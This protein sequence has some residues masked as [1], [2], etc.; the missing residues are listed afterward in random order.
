MRR[1][2]VRLVLAASV[3]HALA[4]PV[5]PTQYRVGSSVNGSRRRAS[6]TPR[7]Q[8]NPASSLL[9]NF[10]AGGIAGTLASVATQPF[11]V[12]KTKMQQAAT[13]SQD[14][15]FGMHAI[16]SGGVAQTLASV[17]QR[18]GI[19]ALWTGALPVLLLAF[20]ESALQLSTHDLCL[21]HFAAPGQSEESLPLLLQVFAGCLSGVPSVLATNPMDMLA[22][23]ASDEQ[24]AA[25]V[26][27]ST[28]LLSNV[29][30]LGLEGLYDGSATTWLRDVPFLGIYFP[31]FAGL[32]ASLASAF[33]SL[34]ILPP[35]VSAVLEA[36]MAGT[37]AGMVASALT[38]PCDVVNVAVK[39]RLMREA[40]PANVFSASL[41]PASPSFP[42]KHSECLKLTTAFSK[43]GSSRAGKWTGRGS[44]PIQLKLVAEVA[45]ELHAEKGP[46]AFF[47]G[48]HA[49]VGQVMPAQSLTICIYN[50]LHWLQS[51]AA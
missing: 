16:G 48:I 31:L 30:A 18:D 25:G 4:F 9:F 5:V 7:M 1:R 10:C 13:V 19:P 43:S 24:Y 38:V 2:L 3:V 41:L 49:R 20:P 51:A 45:R 33:A 29:E 28:D 47:S 32:S 44:F 11:Y 36:L 27:N 37:I 26:A 21:E 8:A 22:I 39:T 34:S 14:D 40:A 17:V 46:G 42:R 23:R 35:E 15:D 6:A 50:L 12:A